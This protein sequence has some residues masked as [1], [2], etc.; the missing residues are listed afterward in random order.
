VQAQ[1]NARPWARIRI[2]GVDVGPTPLS[3]PLAPGVYRIAAEFADG[4]SLQ[5]SVAIGP[6]RRFVALP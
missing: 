4:R 3:R 6:E 5:R 2:D 1:I